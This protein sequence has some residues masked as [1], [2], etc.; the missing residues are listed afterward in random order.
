MKCIFGPVASRR[1]GRSLGVDLIPYKTCSFDCL[2]CELG[3]T[4]NRTLERKDYVSPQKIL[5]EL[6]NFLKDLSPAPDFITLGGSGE[7]TL[8]S[9]IGAIIEEIKKITPTPIAVLT[10]SSLLC[11]DDVREALA[12]ADVILPSLDAATPVVFEYLNRPHPSLNLKKIIQGLIDFRKKFKGE[13]WLEILF[14]LRVNDAPEELIRLKHAVEEINPDKI[15]LNTLDR[16]PAENTVFPLNR[17]QLERI[18]NFFGPRAEIITN[19]LPENARSVIAD[20]K[21]RVYD[22]LKR[23]PCPFDEISLTLG[24]SKIELMD[25]IEM[26]KKEGKVSQRFHNNQVYYQGR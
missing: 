9:H 14:C 4:T 26:L 23:R 1:L 3:V 16:P 22:L 7:P 15:Q 24:I 20:V 6:K 11:R 25:L 13:I 2:Y 5:A 18:K 19:V 12:K 21:K 10:N 8:H 17:E